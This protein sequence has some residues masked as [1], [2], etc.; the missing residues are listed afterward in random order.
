VNGDFR[1]LETHWQKTVQGSLLLSI[2]S[3]YFLKA[4]LLKNGKDIMLDNVNVIKFSKLK[5]S[6]I[7]LESELNLEEFNNEQ[8]NKTANHQ[9][10]IG[11]RYAYMHMDSKSILEFM[12]FY[13]N[14]FAHK[15][16]AMSAIRTGAIS[17][18]YRLLNYLSKKQFGA[19]LW[20]EIP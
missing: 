5:E 9:A 2:G 7:S 20:D 16:F 11:E 3:E 4:V 10:E 18:C 14:S 15:P 1:E 19:L 17:D 13:R 12:H 8:L 6:I